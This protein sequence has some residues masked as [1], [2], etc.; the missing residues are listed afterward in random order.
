MRPTPITE[1]I[2]MPEMREFLTSVSRRLVVVGSVARTIREPK[3]FLPKDIDL[4]CDLDSDKAR[5]EIN[6]AVKK[7]GLKFESPFVSCW[8]F[9]DY[10]WMVE[11]L[12]I[13]YGPF[14]RTVRRRAEQMLIG[15]VELWVAQAEDAPKE[16]AA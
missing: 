13:H 9:R 5:K 8:T 6:A 4:L 14:Y 3:F 2:W 16:R 1:K 7:F 10:G 15:G 11:I 12:G